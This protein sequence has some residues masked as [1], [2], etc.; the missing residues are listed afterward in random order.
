MGVFLFYPR[1]KSALSLGTLI[2]PHLSLSNLMSTLISQEYD[3][4]WVCGWDAEDTQ[5]HLLALLSKKFFLM[6]LWQK[7][8]LNTTERQATSQMNEATLALA[9]ISGSCINGEGMKT[10]EGWERI[11]SHSFLEKSEVADKW[12]AT[13]KAQDNSSPE[14]LHIFFL[15]ASLSIGCPT[16]CLLDLLCLEGQVFISSRHPPSWKAGREAESTWWWT[17]MP[18]GWLWETWV[19]GEQSCRHKQA[20]VFGG[21]FLSFRGYVETSNV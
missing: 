21:A 13:R 10:I 1:A 19:C 18:P 8:R 17:V 4:L 6:L 2:P 7:S 5:S 11:P 16:A 15:N 20:G 14:S 9:A 12:N 3:S